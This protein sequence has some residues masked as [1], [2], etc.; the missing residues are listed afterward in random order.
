MLKPIQ[1]PEKQKKVGEFYDKVVD[2]HYEY[3]DFWRENTLFHWDFWVTLVY[4]TL[5]PWVIWIKY[6]KKESTQRL[7]FVGFYVIII[8]SWLDFIGVTYG[9]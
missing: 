9:F 1:D 2:T 3:L 5:L 7:L 8:S 6:R 4:F